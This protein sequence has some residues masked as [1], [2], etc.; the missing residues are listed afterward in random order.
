MNLGKIVLITL[1]LSFLAT[2]SSASPA[3]LSYITAYDDVT[4]YVGQYSF[5]SIVNRTLKQATKKYGTKEAKH[6]SNCIG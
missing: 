6:L 5:S 1:S 4:Q 2:S 3:S